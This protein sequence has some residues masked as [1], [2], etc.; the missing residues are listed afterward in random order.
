MNA[1]RLS[2]QPS[3]TE[4]HSSGPDLTDRRRLERSA[5][6][7]IIVALSVVLVAVVVSTPWRS[8]SNAVEHD[9]VSA[10]RDR[11]VELSE[12]AAPDDRI[13]EAARSFC[14]PSGPSAAQRAWLASVQIDPA[15]LAQLAQ[16]LCP[17]R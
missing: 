7:W 15:E 3:S 1:I 11:Y 14:A 9:V 13:I 6:R 12:A 10:V 17:S 16:P 8:G 4:P 5:V 2:T